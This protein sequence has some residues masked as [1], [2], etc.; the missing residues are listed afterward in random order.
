MAGSIAVSVAQHPHPGALHITRTG[1]AQ[2]NGDPPAQFRSRLRD[3]RFRAIVMRL[4]PK[5]I[6]HV[7]SLPLRGI[8][9]RLLW[10]KEP[11]KVSHVFPVMFFESYK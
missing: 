6:R 9:V 5:G 11:V 3:V 2:K 10:R 8:P 4:R 1:H 7:V